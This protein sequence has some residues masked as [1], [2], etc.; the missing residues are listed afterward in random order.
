MFLLT[1]LFA[2]SFTIVFPSR[3]PNSMSQFFAI[4]PY[5]LSPPFISLFPSSPSSF[6]STTTTNNNSS[7]SSSSPYSFYSYSS[8][9][10][11]PIQLVFNFSCNKG[12]S[13]WHNRYNT[14]QKKKKKRKTENQG[15]FPHYRLNE[16]EGG[17]I[18]SITVHFHLY[19][20]L[21]IYLCLSVLPAGLCTLVTLFLSV[22]Q[23]CIA[24]SN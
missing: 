10:L 6:S 20:P 21:R 11:P 8:C 19:L 3:F 23:K 12:R 15:W 9:L 17:N 7:S 2:S 5:H 22:L 14:Q 4:L 13:H 18:V 1:I 24:L 16:P